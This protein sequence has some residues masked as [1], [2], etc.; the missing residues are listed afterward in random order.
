MTVSERDRVAM[1]SLF[2]KLRATGLSDARLLAAMERVPRR[3]FMPARYQDDAW[4]DMA[5]PIECGQT[6]PAPSAMA[7]VLRALAGEAGQAVL[8]IGTGSGYQA[9]VLA[10]LGLRVVTV[11]RYRTLADLASDR[12]ASLK[13]DIE[14]VCGDGLDGHPRKAPYDR[15]LLDGAVARIPAVLMDQLSDHG[16]LVA[17]VVSG[18]ATT[19]VRVIRDGRLFNRT[20]LGPVRAATLVEG[21]AARL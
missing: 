15:I 6:L 18:G 2:M 11:E 20:D 17:P 10:M 3:L 1:A 16:V 13:L 12:F 21:L 8:E 4:T 14:S 7:R 9:A 19:L 5:Q